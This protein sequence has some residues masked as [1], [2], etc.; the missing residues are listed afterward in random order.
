MPDIVVHASMGAKAFDR[1][2]MDLDREI[3]RFGLLGPD[4]YLFYNF[5]VPP[6]RHRANRYSSVMHRQ[7]TGDFLAALAKRGKRPEAFAWLA[8]FLCHYALDAGTHPYIIGL[9]KGDIAIHI[10]IEHKLDL[11]DGGPIRIPPFLPP[12]MRA[13]V[14][15]TIGAIYGWPDAWEKLEAGHRHMAPFYRLA[16][17]ERGALN[18]ALG[19]SRRASALSYK[20]HACD[21]MDLGGFWPLYDAAIEAAVGYVRAAAAFVRGDIDEAGFRAVVGSRSYIEG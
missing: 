5:F 8:G 9:A 13:D 11:L 20:S 18:R 6:F 7:R 2:G 1:L 15:D 21:G 12:S 19:W 3:F 16:W 10:A 14:E 17:D 4:P